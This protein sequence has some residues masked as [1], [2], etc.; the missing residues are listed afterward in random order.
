MEETLK[1][2]IEDISVTLLLGDKGHE[3]TLTL[4]YVGYHI[5]QVVKSLHATFSPYI[6]FPPELA[7]LTSRTSIGNLISVK[8]VRFN[9]K[10]NGS[11]TNTNIRPL[12]GVV[13]A[14]TAPLGNLLTKAI[15]HVCITNSSPLQICGSSPE[16]L[17]IT[18][19]NKPPEVANQH[20]LAKQIDITHNSL[21]D[22]SSYKIIRD[23]HIHPIIFL[24]L[25]YLLQATN[26]YG[27]A[28][29]GFLYNFSHGLGKPHLMGLFRATRLTSY[30][31]AN[32][33]RS[34]IIEL[35]END[36][37]LCPTLP[38]IPPPPPSSL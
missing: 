15:H 31:T 14:K 7:R 26:S 37:N 13:I 20:T 16:R 32:Q 33:V 24:K 38:D 28:C 4:R 1:Y 25:I 5:F 8:K 21:H 12:L 10:S 9:K 22:T 6:P 30:L 23:I 35:N 19:H 18:L 11:S 29:K 2:F 36:I 34:Q 17:S 27:N 3:N